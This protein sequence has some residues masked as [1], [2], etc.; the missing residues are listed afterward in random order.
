MLPG[1]DDGVGGAR[2]DG[3][4]PR[5]DGQSP[6]RARLSARTARALAQMIQSNDSIALPTSRR[7]PASAGVDSASTGHAHTT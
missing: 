7:G 6:P 3:R 2:A 1:R 4:G 5:V